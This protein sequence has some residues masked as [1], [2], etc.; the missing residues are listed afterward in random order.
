MKKERWE[1]EAE[2]MDFA[3]RFKQEQI[4]KELAE[5]RDSPPGWLLD[6]WAHDKLMG[7]RR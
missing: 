7:K 4:N 1:I 2:A 6:P 5:K 3:Q